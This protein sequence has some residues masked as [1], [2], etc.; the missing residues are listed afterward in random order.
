[1]GKRNQCLRQEKGSLS[2]N[3][4]ASRENL[5]ILSS[6]HPGIRAQDREMEGRMERG[7]GDE[8]KRRKRRMGP[9]VGAR[10]KGREGRRC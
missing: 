7:R 9:G 8:G 2:K 6:G 10:K 4:A 5:Q 3:L 1:M